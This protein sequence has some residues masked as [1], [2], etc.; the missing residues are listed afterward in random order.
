MASDPLDA[1]MLPDPPVPVG[2]YERGLIRHGLGFLSGQFPIRDGKLAYAGRVGSELTVEEGRSAAEIAA[3]NVIAGIR[4]VL[5][6]SFA[7][8]VGL[9]RVD[10]YVAGTDDFLRQPHVLDGA[11]ETFRRM[12]GERGR[13]ARTAFA[14]PRLPLDSPIELAVTFAALGDRRL[15]QSATFISQ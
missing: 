2:A 8:F 12:L 9:L 13:H 3:I 10:G 5:G 7:G 11:S 6:G 4:A 14:L 1:L 15:L